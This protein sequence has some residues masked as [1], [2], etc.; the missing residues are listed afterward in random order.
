MPF[1]HAV[2]GRYP[3]VVKSHP[4]WPHGAR[5]W[6]LS[7]VREPLARCRSEFYHFIVSRKHQDPSSATLQRSFAGDSCNDRLWDYLAINHDETVEQV[8]DRYHLLLVAERM[9]ESIVAMSYLMQLPLASLVHLAAKVSAE[10]RPDGVG[11]IQIPAPPLDNEPANVQAVYRDG[12]FEE[13]NKRDALLHRLANERLDKVLAVIPNL[14]EQ[15]RLL[16]DMQARVLVQCRPPPGVALKTTG[17]LFQDNFCRVDCVNEFIRKECGPTF[18][19]G[20]LAN[21]V[22]ASDPVG[23]F[24]R[25]VLGGM[26]RGPVAR[27]RNQKAG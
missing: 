22:A 21:R 14:S 10:G 24:E 2:H 12:W 1:V 25:G 7:S 27:A 8:V 20:P 15:L 23:S 6:F 4:E 13:R 9:D 16:R 19:Q 26:S 17:C 18:L 5:T 11:A 3:D